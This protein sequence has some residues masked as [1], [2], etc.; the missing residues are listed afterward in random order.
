MHLSPFD[1]LVSQYVAPPIRK[2]FQNSILKQPGLG[3]IRFINCDPR[4]KATILL[5]SYISSLQCSGFSIRFLP[6]MAITTCFPDNP[7]QNK[8]RI[9][10]HLCNVWYEI[11]LDLF[12]WL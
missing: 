6:L 5:N 10:T 12:L 7:A 8:V 9:L 1:Y 2:V 3:Q 4:R 11:Y